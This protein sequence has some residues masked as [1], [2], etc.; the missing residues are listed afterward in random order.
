CTP[1]AKS[2]LEG[3]PD[4]DEIVVDDK[5]GRA[6]GLRGLRRMARELQSRGFTIA[7]S[8]HKSLRTALLLF[9]ARIPDRVGFRQSVGWFLYHRRVHRD[10]ARHDA[11]RNL[12]ILEPF[13]ASSE[14][15]PKNLRVEVGPETRESVER[16]F[17]SL[18][19]ERNGLIFGLNPGSVWATKRWSAQGY[20]ELMGHLKERYPC[21]LLLF[22]GPEDSQIIDK[23]QELSGGLG[24]SLAGKIGLKELPGA[25]EWCNVFITNDSGP[26]HVAVARGVPVV[27]VFCA[28]TPGL[29]FYP[30]SSRAVV[31]EKDLHCRPCSSHG[32]RRCPLGTEDCIRLVKAEDVLRGVER[33][34]D[35]GGR[36]DPVNSDSHVPQ[37][38][39]L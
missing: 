35:P 30:Y 18:G 10:P 39:T 17:R 13:G 11:E 6:R 5:R 20:A 19:I 21:K 7:L 25:L 3:N 23:I 36:A 16:I 31:V 8:P 26:M 29:G 9:L 27:A 34:L 32:G 14:A 22:G 28:T 15:S 2:L 1:Q 4:L 33:L 38:I 37:F 12:S 24:I